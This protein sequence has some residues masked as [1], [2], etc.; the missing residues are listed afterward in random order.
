[1]IGPIGVNVTPFKRPTEDELAH[2]FLWRAHL[3]CPR[4]GM[5]GILNRP[6]Y[7]DVPFTKVRELAPEEIIR[8]RYDQINAFEKML[9]E[10]GTTILNFDAPHLKDEQAERL[11]A[12]LDEPEK[13]W[14][15]NPGDLD[16]R[17]VWDE[18]QQAYEMALD[19]ARPIGRPGT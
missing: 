19:D 10:N 3:A 16:D 17:A 9:S 4:P 8:Q 11:Q 14:K 12:R 7:E 13:R 15:F 5:I 2:D 18:F 1:M 6:H